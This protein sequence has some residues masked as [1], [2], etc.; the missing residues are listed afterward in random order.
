MIGNISY[1]TNFKEHNGWYVA[2]GGGAKGGKIIG[3]ST[4]RT[5][6][7]SQV[8]LKVPKK[9]NMYSFDM[10]N[11]VP[12]KDL[13]CLFAKA[14][15]NESMICV[16]HKKYCLV[17]TDDFSRFTWVFFLATKDETSR[18]F[19]SF[20]TKIENI[21]KKK[22]KIIRCDNGTQFK[23]RVK[24]EFCEEKGIKR[25]YSVART[26]QQNRVTERRNR[27]LIEVART[28]LADSKIPN[29]F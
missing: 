21:V 4:I 7:E 17:I 2:F 22:V 29:T 28:M 18:I 19:K 23:N 9:N 15:N 1:L 12:Q 14:T 10:K 27:T 8:L 16:M 13:N 11:I 5:V 25:E 6:N 24:N 26:P 20:I 3:K